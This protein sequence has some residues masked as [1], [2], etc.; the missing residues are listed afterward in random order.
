MG[1]RFDELN[2]KIAEQHE[3]FTKTPAHD[4]SRILTASTKAHDNFLNFN[5]GE[6]AERIG[7][8]KNLTLQNQQL[9]NDMNQH[10]MQVAVKECINTNSHNL[11]VNDKYVPQDCTAI[12]NDYNTLLPAGVDSIDCAA[13]VASHS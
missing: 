6:H 12:C 3:K 4:I 2:K 1:N 13:L 11:A 7:Q 8:V 5:N 10:T 9:K